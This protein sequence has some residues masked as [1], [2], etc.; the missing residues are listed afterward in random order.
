MD[1][2]PAVVLGLDVSKAKVD[3]A[4]LAAGKLRSKVIANSPAGFATLDAWLAKHGAG[5]LHACCEATGP[6][7]EALATHLADAGHVVSVVNP[8]TLAAFARTELVRAKTDRQDARLIARFCER[9][10]PEPW[11][12][13]PPAQ[14]RLLALV[15]DLHDLQ[16]M[17]VMEANRLPEAYPDIQP[18][19]Q[20][21]LDFL[22][23]EIERLRTA[24]TEHIDHHDDLRGRRDLLDSVPGLGETTIA[25]LLA[26]L[27]DG[28]RFECAKQAAAFAGLA[29]RLHE[30]GTSVHAHASI[31]KQ[32]HADLRRA[33]YMPA[34]SAYTH[35]AAYAPFVRRLL[36]KGKA[37]KLIITA[38]MRKLITIAQAILKS[39]K[40]FDPALHSG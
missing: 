36:D 24:I 4:L 22:D 18:R 29:P 38:L 26:Y 34:V 27:G 32:G 10:R 19:I 2:F 5:R 37:P 6:Y 21:H 9:H 20:R 28:Q 39:G 12:P 3:C 23:A 15:R 14:R 1:N 33:L 30:S 13:L 16:G 25:W 7:S 40:P 31:D 17:R 8:A 35:C 11:Q